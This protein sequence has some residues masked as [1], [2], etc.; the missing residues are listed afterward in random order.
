MLDRTGG[1]GPFP[2]CPT[3]VAQNLEPHPLAQG[4][5]ML[6]VVDLVSTIVAMVRCTGAFRFI[7]D[8]IG[9]FRCVITGICNM[10]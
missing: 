3:Q 8:K 6:Q 4:Y 5:F 10:K 1:G 9:K 7:I 2:G